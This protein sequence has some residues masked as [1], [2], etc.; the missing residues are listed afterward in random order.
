MRLLESKVK[1]LEEDVSHSRLEWE[2]ERRDL[3][4]NMT[5]QMQ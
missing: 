2:V 1:L 4:D 3:Q 5:H